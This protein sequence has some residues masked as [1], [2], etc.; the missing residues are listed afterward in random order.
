M[1]VNKVCKGVGTSAYT[2]WLNADGGFHSD[3]TMMQTGEDTVRIVTGAFDGGRDEYW[4][5]KHLPQD[6]S[7]TFTNMTESVTTL[8][9]WGPNAPA[10]LGSLTDADVSY[11]GS[12]YGSVIDIEIAGIKCTL[13]RVSYVGDTGWEIYTSW[14]NGPALWDCLLYTS[15]SP[16]DKRQSRMP[17]SA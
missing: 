9:L 13:F 4:I 5:K 2:P 16:R 10:I 12:P 3:L 17:S 1:A 15:P 14:D 6:E 11:E 7:V 8:G